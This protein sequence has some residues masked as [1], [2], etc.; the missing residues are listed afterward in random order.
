MLI[1]LA[2]GNY[3]YFDSDLNKVLSGY[4]GN[5]EIIGR[6]MK[7]ATLFIFCGLMIIP[8]VIE[9]KIH[10]KKYG[11]IEAYEKALGIESTTKAKVAIY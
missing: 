5:D 4:P 7:L 6:V 1:N 8:T 2:S 11:S 9:D 3:M 10:I